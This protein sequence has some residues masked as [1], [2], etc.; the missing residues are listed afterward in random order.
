MTRRRAPRR[1]VLAALPV[2][3]AVS[4]GGVAHAYLSGSGSGTGTATTRTTVA[5]TLGPGTPAGDLYPGGQADVVLT[6]S[7]PNA[8][9]V[10]IGSLTLD[11]GQGTGGFAVDP[12]HA[13]LGCTVAAATLSFTSSS[14][15][16][17]VT[18]SG[19]LPVTLT[20]A[21]GMG[22]GAASACQG[23]TFKVYVAAG[24]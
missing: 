3:L 4:M 10:R 23:A 12:P 17:P 2:I 21:L 7:N 11:P 8:S 1:L 13:G 24:P 19:S 18:G 22:V 16:W 9:D 15:G 14:V 20:D 6:V 5:V